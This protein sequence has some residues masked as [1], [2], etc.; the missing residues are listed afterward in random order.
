L[1]IMGKLRG[2]V[3]STGMAALLAACGGGDERRAPAPDADAAVDAADDGPDAATKA[4]ECNGGAPGGPAAACGCPSDCVGQVCGTEREGV[5][6]GGFCL[7]ACDPAAPAPPGLTCNTHQG[8]S[9]YVQACG[10]GVERP[11]RDGWFCRVYLGASRPLDRYMCE[12]W[13]ND[14]GQCRTGHCNRYTGICE[15]ASEGLPNG[16]R[17]TL[18]EQCRGGV[19]FRFGEG[20]CT[21]LCDVRDGYCPDDGF[22]LPPVQVASGAHNGSCL[23][24]CAAAAD[25][26]A[27][28]ACRAA[29]GARVCLPT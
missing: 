12:A 14:D 1:D 13:C 2:L 26:Q 27:G 4:P 16:A 6:A 21:S 3:G 28:F 15:P 11:C 18:G 7:E 29:M 10:P 8:Q 17:C 24:R 9:F 23:K 20:M 25:C 19:C 5:G 22:C